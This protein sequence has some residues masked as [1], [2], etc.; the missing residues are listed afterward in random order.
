[1]LQRV[2]MN[3]YEMSD[4]EMLVLIVA[5]LGYCLVWSKSVDIPGVDSFFLESERGQ[6]HYFEGDDKYALALTYMR[7]VY[8]EGL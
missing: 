8:R 3:D 2:V 6:V 4:Y 1:M 7:R 5:E